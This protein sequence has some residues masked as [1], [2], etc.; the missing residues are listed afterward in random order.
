MNIEFLGRKAIE[1][2]KS[3]WGLPLHGF[4]AGGSIA[5]LVWEMVSGNKAVVNDIDIFVFD[6]IE[7]FNKEK[8]SLFNYQEQETK[9]YED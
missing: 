4:L 7:E 3:E 1:R 6:G 9:Y 5:N 2:I 8:K